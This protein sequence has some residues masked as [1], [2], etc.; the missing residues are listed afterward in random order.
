MACIH[1]WFAVFSLEL[2]GFAAL[3]FAK[4]RWRRRSPTIIITVLFITALAFI[5]S[6][7]N[8][9]G[10]SVRDV[11]PFNISNYMFEFQLF[12]SN[13][14][15]ESEEDSME[16]LE[17]LID[18]AP[19]IEH[20]PY[21]EYGYDYSY[22]MAA[23]SCDYDNIIYPGQRIEL[24]N[25]SWDHGYEENKDIDVI[26]EQTDV[27]Y[28]F[29]GAGIG[30]CNAEEENVVVH[31]S[32]SQYLEHHGNPKLTLV[33]AHQDDEGLM[34]E[35]DSLVVETQEALV[36]KIA[37]GMYAEGLDDSM[38]V[39]YYD[40]PEETVD[41]ED[42]TDLLESSIYSPLA[43]DND[44]DA[45]VISTS[46]DVVIQPEVA[47][48]FPDANESTSNDIISTP[49][50]LIQYN[51]QKSGGDSSD[52][53]TAI[54]DIVLASYHSI[55]DEPVYDSGTLSQIIEIFPDPLESLD[56]SESETE[57][58]SDDTELIAQ[59]ELPAIVE[60]PVDEDDDIDQPFMTSEGNIGLAH[61][62]LT[63]RIL[64]E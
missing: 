58:A 18:E 25:L 28:D 32:W 9:Y 60:A 7:D 57:D 30:E 50:E 37:A 41:P 54:N 59:N 42:E 53:A 33:T 11:V 31:E 12:A 15:D 21:L 17:R 2:V 29:Y 23:V 22:D 52:E 63:K 20:F 14:E 19:F 51:S 3:Q 4:P 1:F 10:H 5:A 62:M 35:I 27:S 64:L 24:P 40:I 49:L 48:H 46:D 43:D 44:D 56:E 6:R 38:E 61:Y 45:Y 39:D 47:I 13:L 34:E 36:D 16:V 55:I 8:K 26:S